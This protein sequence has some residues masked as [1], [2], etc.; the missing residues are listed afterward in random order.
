MASVSQGMRDDRTAKAT[1][2]Q[3]EITVELYLSNYE[4][5]AL[6]QLVKRIGWREVRVNAVDDAEAYAMM[7]A[8][9]GVAKALASVGIAPR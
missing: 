7:D 2:T 8:V 6:A 5:H 1:R 4:A 9:N 3:T